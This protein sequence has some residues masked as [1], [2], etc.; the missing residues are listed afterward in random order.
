[1]SADYHGPVSLAL[2]NQFI[3]HIEAKDLDAAVALV[4]DDCEYDNVPMRKVYGPSGI[5]ESL[6]GFLAPAT[7]V[8]WKI[9]REAAAGNVVFNERTDEFD[10]PT[11]NISIPVTGVFEIQGG[12]IALWR[13]YF[14]LQTFVNQTAKKD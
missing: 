7:R 9:H 5:K 12:K 4:T 13:D 8:E 3:R 6:E 2:V 14:D 10:F 1:L 11:G